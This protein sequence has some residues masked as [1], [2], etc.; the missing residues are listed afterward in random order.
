MSN[1]AP[2]T[3]QDIPSDLSPMLIINELSI[4]VA[5][6]ARDNAILKA[7]VR[8]LQDQIAQMKK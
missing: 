1:P 7:T 2:I 8:T 4:Q 3:A 5:N 6:Y